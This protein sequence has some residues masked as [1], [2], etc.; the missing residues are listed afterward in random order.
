MVKN[1]P[2]ALVERLPPAVATAVVWSTTSV[3]GSDG[4]FDGV[5]V[6]GCSI[7]AGATVPDLRAA[8]ALADRALLP[9][10][11]GD[12]VVE[13]LGPMIATR[14]SKP[15]EQ[16]DLEV[17]LQVLAERMAPFPR[18]VLVEASNHFID[19]SPWMPAISEFLTVVDRLMRPR[20]AFKAALEQAIERAS[21]PARPALPAVPDTPE[22][23]RENAFSRLRTAI[24]MRRQ[25]GD[26][27]TA[28]R[29]EVDLAGR[30]KREPEQWARDHIAEQLAKQRAASAEYQ[31]LADETAAAKPAAPLTASQQALAELA[32]KRRAE[33]LRSPEP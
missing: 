3:F 15:G 9:A 23:R 6:N 10:K 33:I 17:A 2:A 28:A 26:E 20:R 7:K 1:L 25:A 31:R 19:S 21:Q 27:T 22:H 32:E 24:S 13:A 14:R 4:Q 29:F 12:E 8:L 5:V 11:N 30:E 16:I 18:S